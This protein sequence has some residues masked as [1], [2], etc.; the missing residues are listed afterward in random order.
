MR[1]IRSMD[2]PDPAAAL[3]PEEF[4]CLKEVAVGQLRHD[5]SPPCKDRLTEL[6]LIEERLGDLTLTVVGATRLAKGR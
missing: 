4:A 5:T 2:R 6:G 3:T 1:R